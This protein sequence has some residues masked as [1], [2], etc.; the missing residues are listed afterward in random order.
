MPDG[1]RIVFPSD[2]SGSHQLFWKQADG[3]GTAEQLTNDELFGPVTSI[4]PDGKLALATLTSTAEEDDV[5]FIELQRE[6][7]TLPAV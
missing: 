2:R 6:R 3:T 7:K 1:N 5:G 4:S